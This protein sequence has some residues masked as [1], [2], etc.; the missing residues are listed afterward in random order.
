MVRRP[1]RR[2]HP[3]SGHPAVPSSGL[4]ANRMRPQHSAPRPQA[5][6]RGPHWGLRATPHLSARRPP[7]EERVRADTPGAPGL[8]APGSRHVREARGAPRQA[9]TPRRE[10]SLLAR[11]LP[12]VLPGGGG[13]PPTATP[14]GLGGPGSEQPTGGC[15]GPRRERGCAA[16]Q[17]RAGAAASPPPP[18]P[19]VSLSAGLSFPSLTHQ[20][21]QGASEVGESQ[22]DGRK[23]GNVGVRGRGA[24]RD[25]LRRLGPSRVGLG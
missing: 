8:A 19:S 2:P 10:R 23:H 25:R 4:S 6:F 24:G 5:P 22:E 7:R 14:P 9:H 21:Q 17:R 18:G 16:R 12:R 1:R 13:L 3:L 11:T 15:R 20:E